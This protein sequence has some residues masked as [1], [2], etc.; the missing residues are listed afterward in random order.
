MK[1]ITVKSLYFDRMSCA[2]FL[3]AKSV[4]LGMPCKV[5]LIELGKGSFFTSG[6]LLVISK[7]AADLLSLFSKLL[8]KR[9]ANK[10]LL[11]TVSCIFWF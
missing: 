10:I 7:I 3:F 4:S 8:A 9:F 1:N 2:T 6:N 11:L 5:V